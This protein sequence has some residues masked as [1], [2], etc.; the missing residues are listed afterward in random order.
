MERR[1][2]LYE[3]GTY[4]T[5]LDLFLRMSADIRVTLTT[6]YNRIADFSCFHPN[7]SYTEYSVCR[8][9]VGTRAPAYKV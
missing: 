3:H 9:G 6:G 5:Y 7:I 2:Y 1:R 8:V 4:M